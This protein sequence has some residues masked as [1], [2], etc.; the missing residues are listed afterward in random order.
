ML[1]CA[2]GNVCVTTLC[3]RSAGMKSDDA[4]SDCAAVISPR[5][6]EEWGGEVYQSNIWLV[7]VVRRVSPMQWQ[8]V[9]T[10]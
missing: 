6:R 9:N 10:A 1:T 2:C 8:S 7:C 5:E 4:L 3:L